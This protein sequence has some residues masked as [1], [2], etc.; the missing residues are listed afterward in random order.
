[1]SEIHPDHFFDII[2]LMIQISIDH[3]IPLERCGRVH[4]LFLQ[5]EQGNYKIHRLRFLHKIEAELNLVWREFIARRLMK[6]S[7][8]IKPLSM[9]STEAEE[10][11]QQSM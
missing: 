7:E 9:S 6:N 5:K 2:T 8:N 10:E 3:S 1:M 11:D 4:N